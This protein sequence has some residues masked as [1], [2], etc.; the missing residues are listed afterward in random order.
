MKHIRL[1]RIHTENLNLEDRTLGQLQVGDKT[2]CTIEKPWVRNPEAPDGYGAGMRNV[3]CV[4]EGEYELVLR[5]SPSKG[6]QWHFVNQ[7]LGVFLEWSENLEPW[8]RF[9]CMFH[10]A[11]YVRQVEGCSGVGMRV[12]DFGAREGFGVAS[13]AMGMHVL[14]EYL[15]GE[16]RARLTIE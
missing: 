5:D 9:S 1:T 16:T 15:Q 12:F 11:N 6:E 10:I 7:D 14:K 13:S 8:H 2:L 3:S 4:P